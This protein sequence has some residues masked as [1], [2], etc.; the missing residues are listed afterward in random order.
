MHAVKRL[1]D[2]VSPASV[3]VG[4]VAAVG[5]II[6]GV[7]WAIATPSGL[8][9]DALVATV[10]LSTAVAV[11]VGGVAYLLFARESAGHIVA[12]GLY[13]VAAAAAA[14][15]LLN[16]LLPWLYP[17]FGTAPPRSVV[18]VGALGILFVIGWGTA[19]VCAALGYAVDRFV[20]VR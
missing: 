5:A 14:F 15:P 6:V 9:L 1:R 10:P 12:G 13:L 4:V 3:G 7:A 8:V 18:G 16:G 11:G 19:I 17:V 20:S 2:V